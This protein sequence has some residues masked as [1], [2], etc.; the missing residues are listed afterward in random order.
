[1]EKDPVQQDH[2]TEHA[3][4]GEYKKTGIGI[5]IHEDEYKDHESRQQVCLC[6]D[7]QEWI[8]FKPVTAL[9]QC[10][11]INGRHPRKIPNIEKMNIRPLTESVYR[12]KKTV[13]KNK[14]K[15]QGNPISKPQQ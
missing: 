8:E 10:C 13:H 15:D 3:Y 2:E 4:R 14:N 12:W 11:H 9:I 5:L 6:R 1:M 7:L